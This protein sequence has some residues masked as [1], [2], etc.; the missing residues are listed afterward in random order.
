MDINNAFNIPQLGTLSGTGNLGEERAE[1]SMN[2]S[3]QW[4]ALSLTS[5]HL[6]DLDV[7]RVYRIPGFQAVEF[8]TDH[9]RGLRTLDVCRVGESGEWT[10]YPLESQHLVNF[11]WHVS[12]EIVKIARVEG[13]ARK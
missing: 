10:M 13:L 5:A 4:I 9:G 2:E 7:R 6:F 3:G 8:V 12:T 1:L 11:A